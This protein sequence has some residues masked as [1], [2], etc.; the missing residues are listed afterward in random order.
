MGGHGNAGGAGGVESDVAEKTDRRGAV[1]GAVSDSSEGHALVIDE[2]KLSLAPQAGVGVRVS[3][4]AGDEGLDSHTS[5]VVQ[6]EASGTGR[7]ARKVLA[8]ALGDH[9]GISDAGVVGEVVPSEAVLAG[10]DGGVDGAVVD[11]RVHG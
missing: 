4:A 11:G 8:N 9:N 5:S 7:A 10:G 2:V 6:V 1:Q 3:R